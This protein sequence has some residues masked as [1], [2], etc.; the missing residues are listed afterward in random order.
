[1][2]EQKGKEGSRFVKDFYILNHPNHQSLCNI[3]L[4]SKSDTVNLDL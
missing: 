3:F 4:Y 2:E 1:M